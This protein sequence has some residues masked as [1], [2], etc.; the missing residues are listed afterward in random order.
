MCCSSSVDIYDFLYFLFQTNARVKHETSQRSKLTDCTET[1]SPQKVNISLRFFHSHFQCEGLA[2]IEEKKR[3]ATQKTWF[4]HLSW[5]FLKV[6]CCDADVVDRFILHT[7]FSFSIES[8]SL[9]HSI[10]QR[11]SNSCGCM[12]RTTYDFHATVHPYFHRN[13]GSLMCWG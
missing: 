8:L 9:S 5:V 12:W 6:W 2:E 7:I 1:Q 13:R 11:A 3:E 10:K 4:V